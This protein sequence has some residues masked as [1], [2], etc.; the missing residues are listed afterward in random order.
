MTAQNLTKDLIIVAADK[1]LQ[2]TVETLLM[3]RNQALRIA[4]IAVDVLRH[5]QKD[6]GC[7]SASDLFLAPA[8]NRYEKAMVLFDY[9]GCGENNLSAEDLEQR[10]EAYY[11][12]RGWELDTVAFI[13]IEPEL[14]AW[15]FGASTRHLE[16]A[17][18]WSQPQSIRHWLELHGHTAHG[19]AKPTDPQTALDEMLQTQGKRRSRRLFAD[20][21]R[22]VS[23]ARCQDRAF[24][25]FR[26]TLQ[27]W[28]PAQ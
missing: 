10:L 13:V 2:R 28:F 17:V 12:T 1:Q 20:L 18:G 14:E 6:P 5:P 7:R 9:H 26:A 3:H 15:V 22:R 16:S 25:K 23:L 24:Q 27:R 8:R 21:A 11:L 4:E 19:E